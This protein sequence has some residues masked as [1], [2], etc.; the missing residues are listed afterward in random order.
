MSVRLRIVGHTGE[1]RISANFAP[2]KSASV[3]LPILSAASA[4]GASNI[5]VVGVADFAPGQ[6]IMIDTG[7]SLETAVIGVLIC[8]RRSTVLHVSPTGPPTRYNFDQ[9]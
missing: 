1:S 9:R 3:R 2:V 7:A 4:A 8:S 5:K 6:T